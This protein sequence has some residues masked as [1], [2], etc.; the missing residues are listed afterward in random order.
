MFWRK[1][2]KLVQNFIKIWINLTRVFPG[3]SLIKF[4]CK[5]TAVSESMI[6]QQNGQNCPKNTN[7]QIFPIFLPKMTN[8][9]SKIIIMHISA[10]FDYFLLIS[11]L[12][13]CIS[14]LKA[15]WRVV[16]EKI[17]FDQKL[18]KL[19]QKCMYQHSLTMNISIKYR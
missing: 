8:L 15:I 14:N 19:P 18:E 13:T 1:P 10:Q 17:I 5:Q 6:F 11:S 16:S 7:M 4:K 9:A 2:L 12:A 3:N